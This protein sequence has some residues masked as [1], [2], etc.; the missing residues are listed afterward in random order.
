[1]KQLTTEANVTF[2]LPCV[3]TVGAAEAGKAQYFEEE[4]KKIDNIKV[5]KLEAIEYEGYHPSLKGT[6]S[7]IE[8]IQ[9]AVG[10]EIIMEGARDDVVT[11]RKYSNVQPMYKAGCRGCNASEYTPNLC[12][13]CFHLAESVD[14]KRLDDMIEKFQDSLFPKLSGGFGEGNDFNMKEVLKRGH[15]P[16]NDEST[17]KKISL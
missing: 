17:S 1:M 13:V 10:E 5:V 11:N 14:T 6:F 2:I 7:I 16:S 3:P 8:Q 4:I 15:E 12:S 9:I